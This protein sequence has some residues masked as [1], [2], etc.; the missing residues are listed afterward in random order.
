MKMK[1][2][3]KRGKNQFKQL[4]NSQFELREKPT[5]EEFQQKKNTEIKLTLLKL[6]DAVYKNGEK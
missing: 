2:K 1:F 4:K 5:T 3:L 6:N